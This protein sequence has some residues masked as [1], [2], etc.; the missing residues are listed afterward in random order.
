MRVC[1][2]DRY[3]HACVK[4]D[5]IDFKMADS[6]IYNEKVSDYLDEDN[7]NNDDKSTLCGYNCTS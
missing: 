4:N 5:V 3:R 6:I 2:R 7:V 1:A